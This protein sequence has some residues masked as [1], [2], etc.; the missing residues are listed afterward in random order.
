MRSSENFTALTGYFFTNLRVRVERLVSDASRAPATRGRRADPRRK[1]IADQPDFSGAVVAVVREER[2]RRGILGGESI[3]VALD[4]RGDLQGELLAQLHT[5]LVE[6]VDAPDRALREGD[7]L[8]QGD[9]LTENSR[10]ERGREDRRGRP[11]AREG[12]SGDE[13]TRRPFGLDLFSRLSERQCL[14]LGEEVR[15]EQAG[16]TKAM[17]SA[18]MRRVPWWISW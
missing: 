9:Q 2:G 18:G 14:G 11:V 5:P 17:K 3:V 15:E 4:R 16:L 12:P 10:R 6:R 8:V 1:K 13:G 7:V